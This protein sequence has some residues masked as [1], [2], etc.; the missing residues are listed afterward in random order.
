MSE[1]TRLGSFPSAEVLRA[2][3][4]AVPGSA[5]RIIGRIE[6]EAEHRHRQEERALTAQIEDARAQRAAERRGQYLGFSIGVFAISCGTYA[7]V[8]NA[9]ISGSFIGAGG[10]IGLVLAFIAGRK[11]SPPVLPAEVTPPARATTRRGVATFAAAPPR[12]Q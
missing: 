4:E 6:A 1:A 3:N 10:V 9:Q 12:Q 7:G 11:G 8:H 2:Y 5:E